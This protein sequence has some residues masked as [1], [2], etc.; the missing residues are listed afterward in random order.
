MN[1]LVQEPA[2]RERFGYQ[3]RLRARRFTP[4]AIV[5]QFVSLYQRAVS[6]A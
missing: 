3:A 2:L 6:Q 5:P 1:Q 4:A